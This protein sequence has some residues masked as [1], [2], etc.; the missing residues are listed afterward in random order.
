MIDYS[1]LWNK[2]IIKKLTQEKKSD[3]HYAPEVVVDFVDSK[4]NPT[5]LLSTTERT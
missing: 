2:K 4:E 5:D 1:L 3:R